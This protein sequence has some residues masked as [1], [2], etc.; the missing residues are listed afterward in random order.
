[1]TNPVDVR[2]LLARLVPRAWNAEQALQA[3]DLLQHAIDAIWCVHGQE[4]GRRRLGEHPASAPGRQ[5]EG[6]RR[7]P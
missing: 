4:M 5:A 1:M 3:V 2:P 7:A 6:P